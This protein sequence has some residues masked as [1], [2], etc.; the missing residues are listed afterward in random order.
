MKLTTESK[1]R[2]KIK[3]SFLEKAKIFYSHNHENVF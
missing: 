2:K 1:K 3:K